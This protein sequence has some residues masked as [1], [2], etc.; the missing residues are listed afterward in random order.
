MENLKDKGHS[1]K[2]KGYEFRIRDILEKRSDPRTRVI[3]AKKNKD[4]SS[5]RIGVILTE[6]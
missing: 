1:F 2:N 5:S 4:H 3:L 6:E